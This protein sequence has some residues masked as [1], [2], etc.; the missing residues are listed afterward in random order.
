MSAPFSEGPGATRDGLQREQGAEPGRVGLRGGALRDA[1]PE[2]RLRPRVRAL[3]RALRAILGAR[4]ADGDDDRR[5]CPGRQHS[6][7]RKTKLVLGA[8]GIGPS[9]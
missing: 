4:G 2:Q 8:K 1:A 5:A 3:L 7:D 6:D 9:R